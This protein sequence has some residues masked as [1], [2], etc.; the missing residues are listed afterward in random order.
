[1]NVSRRTRTTVAAALALSFLGSAAR[2]EAPSAHAVEEARQ[3]FARGVELYKEGDYRATLL[4]LRRA[5]SLAPNPRILFN[6]GQTLMM[7]QQ[8]AAARDAFRTYL[9]Q[10]GSSLPAARRTQVEEELKKLEARVGKLDLHVNVAGAEVTIDDEVVGTTPLPAPLD[11]SAGRRKVV[12]TSARGSVTRYID[13]TGTEVV[14]VDLTI[15]EPSSAPVAVP[16]NLP[17]RPAPTASTSAPSPAER[18]HASAAPWISLGVTAIF[19]G[20]AVASG[21]FALDAKRDLDDRARTRDVDHDAIDSARDRARLFTIGTDALGACAIVA[22]GVTTYLF[23]KSS[24]SSSEP[25][26]GLGVA[27]GR[28]ALSGQF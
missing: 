12:V 3:H 26:V 9:E 1:M 17:S 14:S 10:S 27:P 16:V 19:A 7:L 4:E 20:G 18:P 11:V 28:V 21:I 24:S 5:Y 15:V 2:A 25:R 22:A 23:I 6:I 8:Y 13:V